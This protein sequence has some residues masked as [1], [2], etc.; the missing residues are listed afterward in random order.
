LWF[1]SIARKNWQRI[2][3]VGSGGFLVVLAAAIWLEWL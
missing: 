3:E 2:A 1:G